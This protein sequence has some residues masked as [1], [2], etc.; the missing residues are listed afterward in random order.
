MTRKEIINENIDLSFDFMEKVLD[1]PA[2]LNRIPD[3]ANVEFVKRD[4]NP[5]KKK[6]HSKQL[7]TKFIRVKNDFELL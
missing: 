6:S 4:L 3:G 2:I 1:V 7:R 5:K